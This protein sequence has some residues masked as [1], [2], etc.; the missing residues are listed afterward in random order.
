[1]AKNKKPR[2]QR[3]ARAAYVP[4]MP[5][6]RD[7]LALSLHMAVE[8]LIVAPSIDT[9]NSLSTKFCTL[10]NAGVACDSLETAKRALIDVCDRFERV[11]KVGVNEAE[12]AALRA[13]VGDLDAMLGTVPA[14]KLVAAEA[15]TAVHCDEMG[16]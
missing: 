2:K 3:R 8:A 16:I 11:G 10:G 6:T 12:A 4:M 14:N 9:Y 13:T 5:E 1:M 15:V 7:R